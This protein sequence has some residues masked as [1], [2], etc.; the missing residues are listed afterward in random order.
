MAD[1]NIYGRLVN[2]MEDSRLADTTQI[3]D[4]TLHKSQSEING[5]L[6]TIDDTSSSQSSTWSSNKISTEL[7]G[8]QSTLVSGTNIKTINTQSLLGS[9]DI[10][11]SGGGGDIP[12]IKMTATTATLDQNKFYVWGEVASL[13]I[14]LAAETA[15]IQNVYK[16]QFQSGATAT[17]L[18][19]PN[20]VSIDGD[21]PN[22]IKTTYIVSIESNI[23]K[24]ERKRKEPLLPTAYQQVEYIKSSGL[25]YIDIG[26]EGSGS[27]SMSVDLQADIG[28]QWT[29]GARKSYSEKR[30]FVFANMA[31]ESIPNQVF[32]A[33][34]NNSAN[35]DYSIA[36][37]GLRHIYTI[38]KGSFSID[39]TI[40]TS[41]TQ[42]VFTT[43]NNLLL[44]AFKDTYEGEKLKATCSIYQATISNQ[45]TILADIYPCYRKADNVAGMYDI[46]RNVFLTN[47]GTGSFIVGP[48]V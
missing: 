33:Y 45:G 14:S 23:A 39:N 36:N 4:P 19:L 38:D 35:I 17:T 34:G 27:Y 47:A 26:F 18:T 43:S 15:G 31:V 11:I 37:D 20:D 16:F 42:A 44:F 29:F 46:V 3:Y 25:Q 9:G 8:K 5:N 2:Q 24:I 48:D 6:A 32:V 41:Y 1:I 22:A 30:N 28:Q 10:H 12:K 13:D 7:S 40:I 21:Y